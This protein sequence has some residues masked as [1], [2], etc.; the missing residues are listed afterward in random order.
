MSDLRG[1]AISQLLAQQ[2]TADRTADDTAQAAADSRQLAARV[3]D[4]VDRISSEL[5]RAFGEMSERL[6]DTVRRTSEQLHSTEWHGRSRDAMVALDADLAGTTQ[7]FLVS[8]QEGVATFRANLMAFI[9]D[10]YDT[11]QTQFTGSMDDVRARY[12]TAARATESY[13]QRLE[14]LDNTAITV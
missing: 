6:Q 14:E 1:G 13:A 9:T 2:T 10:F 12:T 5:D 8:S 3:Q 11:V 4:E 7:R